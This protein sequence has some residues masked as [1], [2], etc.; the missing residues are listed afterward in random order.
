MQDPL[1]DLRPERAAYVRVSGDF[2]TIAAELVNALGVDGAREVAAITLGTQAAAAA[3]PNRQIARV[4]WRHPRWKPGRLEI[5]RF[6]R[7]GDASNFAMRLDR[8]H[9]Q[10]ELSTAQRTDWVVLAPALF[11]PNL[12]PE[13][14]EHLERFR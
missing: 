2:T 3:Q 14:R 12:P 9:Y 13:W 7:L 5:R 10:N 1:P 6:E 4:R 11:T 8:E